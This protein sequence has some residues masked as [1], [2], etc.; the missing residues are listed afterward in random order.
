MLYGAGLGDGP[1]YTVYYLRR[2]LDRGNSLTNAA[3][4]SSILVYAG[5]YFI[6]GGL[7]FSVIVFILLSNISSPL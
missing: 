1:S 4:S 2:E 5:I 3:K 7:I 6:S